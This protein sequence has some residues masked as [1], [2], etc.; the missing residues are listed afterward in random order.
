MVQFTAKQIASYLKGEIE[1]NPDSK[2]S[3]FAKIEEGREGA[4][5]FLANPKYAH[6]LYTTKSTIVLVNKDFQPEQPVKA[7]LVKVDN[8]Y[9]AIARLLTLYE[10][11]VPAKTGISEQAFIDETAE[12]GKDCYVAPFVYI[13]KNAVIGDHVQLYPGVVIGDGVH[14]GDNSLLYPNV[15]VYHGCKLGKRVTLHAGTVIGAD[16]FGFAPTEHGYDK[17][18]QIGIVTIE[19]DV[20]IGANSCVDRSTMG[21]T[22][23]RKGVK[24]DNLVQVAHN[25]EIGENTVMSA[26]TGVAGSTKIG[27]W[28]MFGGQVGISGHIKIGDRVMV[29]AQAGI[30]GSLPKGNVTLQGSPAIEANNF[31]RSS[32]VFKKL[33]ELYRQINQMSRELDNLK[34]QLKQ[35]QK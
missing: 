23:V 2:V 26:Q 6:Y 29:G 3:D 25:V 8:A 7:T 14:I 35:I 22:Y 17:I 4:I 19:S 30:S 34:E 5:S 32:V 27:R 11:T 21:T 20:E 18:P 24:L 16:G 31:W 9:D 33:P 1:G 15:T 12:V 13:G 10:S 28:C